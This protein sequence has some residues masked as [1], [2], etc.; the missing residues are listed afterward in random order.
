MNSEVNNKMFIRVCARTGAVSVDSVRNIVYLERYGVAFEDDHSK[1]GNAKR[2][3]DFAN[4][5][6]TV[7]DNCVFLFATVNE[8][9]RLKQLD[10][11]VQA[12]HLNNWT[13]I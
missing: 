5:E 7:M 4:K 13:E 8:A 9:S 6:L 12:F 2:A 3:Y 10:F 11:S 1:D